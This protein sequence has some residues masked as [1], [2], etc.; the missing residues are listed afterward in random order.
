MGKLLTDACL[1]N[2][3][4]Q[5]DFFDELRSLGRFFRPHLCRRFIVGNLGNNF[6]QLKRNSKESLSTFNYLDVVEEP[7]SS[8]AVRRSRQDDVHGVS[9]VQLRETDAEDVLPAADLAHQSVDA[10]QWVAVDGP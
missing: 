6:K 8:D 4:G 5:R 3:A 1:Q 7:H 2:G 10:G 9:L